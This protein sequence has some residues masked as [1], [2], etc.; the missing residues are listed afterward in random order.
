MVEPQ[1]CVRLLLSHGLARTTST[2]D[3]AY[4][5]HVHHHLQH[6]LQ[7]TLLFSMAD[8]PLVVLLPALS[9]EAENHT[10]STAPGFPSQ[11]R[12][13]HFHHPGYTRPV[14]MFRLAAYDL[15]SHDQS[16]KQA[17]QSATIRGIHHG[18]AL[19]ACCIVAC[20]LPGFLSSIKLDQDDYTPPI[21][22]VDAVLTESDY[23]YYPTG[24]DQRAPPYP[25][26][27]N[28]ENWRYPST[29]PPDWAQMIVTNTP[30]QGIRFRAMLTMIVDRL[31]IKDGPLRG[32]D[33]CC[34]PI[35]HHG[36]RA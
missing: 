17:A 25:V 20:S 31:R 30:S 35:Q 11:P 16:V 9:A 33:S 19:D 3:F 27:P 34:F 6:Q 2:P 21:T 36:Q 5:F 32:S 28:F 1:S 24:W 23:W 15:P 29:P 7:H 8:L 22:P 18:T 14:A 12:Y 4:L 13:V 10:P 26:V